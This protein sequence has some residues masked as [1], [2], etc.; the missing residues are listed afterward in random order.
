MGK[1]LFLSFVFLFVSGQTFARL[2]NEHELPSIGPDPSEQCEAATAP[3]VAL[4]EKNCKVVKSNGQEV[5][6]KPTNAHWTPEACK[7]VWDLIKKI[8]HQAEP[9]KQAYDQAWLAEYKKIQEK[10][11]EIK[12]FHKSINPKYYK[13]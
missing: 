7:E 13:R 9:D 8:E 3:L 1:K 11:K 12:E 2:P 6:L 5:K 10:N 4:L